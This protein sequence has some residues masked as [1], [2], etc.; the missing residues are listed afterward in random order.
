[1]AV[2]TMPMMNVGEVRMAMG[3]HLMRVRVCV[4]LARR[5]VGNMCMT[6]VFIVDMTM[7]VRQRVVGVSMLVALREM[8]PKSQRHQSGRYKE[9]R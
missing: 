8:Q 4:R 1:M 5:I 3:E 7:T 6:M 2:V 9:Q